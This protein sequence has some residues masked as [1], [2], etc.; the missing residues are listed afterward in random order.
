[1]PVDIDA[2]LELLDDAYVLSPQTKKSAALRASPAAWVDDD[3]VLDPGGLVAYRRAGYALV[4]WTTQLGM[5]WSQRIARARALELRIYVVVFDQSMRRAFAVDPDGTI[6][7]GTFG[8]YGLAS[9]AFDPRKTA[10][11]LV[12][13]GTDISEGLERIEKIRG[14]QQVIR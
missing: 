13:P 7:A 14:A 9:F 8:E 4:A 3:T 11:T 2:R 10:E 12:A 5:P 1:L 6:L